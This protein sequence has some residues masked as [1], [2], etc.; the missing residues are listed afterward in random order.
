M[1][2]TTSEDVDFKTVYKQAYLMVTQIY[3]CEDVRV[4]EI[5]YA[6]NSIKRLANE[7]IEYLNDIREIKEL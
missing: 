6:L 5:I 2:K 3:F 1:K 4:D 7:L